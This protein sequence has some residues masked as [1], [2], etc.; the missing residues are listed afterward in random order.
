MEAR[1]RIKRINALAEE[2]GRRVAALGLELAPPDEL[3]AAARAAELPK[4]VLDE[5]SGLFAEIEAQKTALAA[6]RK[7]QKARR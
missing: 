6:Q 3:L 5:L 7:K 1:L 4:S 2:A